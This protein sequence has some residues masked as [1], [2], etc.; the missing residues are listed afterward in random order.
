MIQVKLYR[1]YENRIRGYNITGHAGYDVKGEDIVCAA[2][3][4]LAQTILLALVKVCKIKKKDIDYSI[5]EG[6]MDVKIP[7]IPDREQDIKVEALL[8]TFEVGI[9]AIVES[10]PGYVVIENREV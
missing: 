4:V 1:D 6:N 2:V 10:Y 7:N 3:S 9:E 5:D 8:N